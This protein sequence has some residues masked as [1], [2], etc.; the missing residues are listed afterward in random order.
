MSAAKR[1]LLW[2]VLWACATLGGLGLGLQPQIGTAGPAKARGGLRPTAVGRGPVF[3]QGKPPR[4]RAEIPATI[5]VANGPTMLGSAVYPAQDIPLRFTHD[6]H[7]ALGLSCDRCHGGAAT[8]KRS[9]DLLIPTGEA[10]DECH[11][12]QH[13]R[14]DDEPMRCTLCHTQVEDGDRLTASVRM[15]RPLLHFNHEL[16]TRRGSDCKDCHDMS[17]VRLGS[18]LQLPSEASCLSCH[19]G[20]QATARCGACHPAGSDGRLLMRA[21]DDRTLPALIP[22]GAS[23]WGAAHDLNF[24]ED[25]AAIS[26]SNGKL[27]NSCHDDAFCID[28]HD[29]PIRPMR[30]HAGDYL[31]IHAQDARAAISDCQSCHRTQSFCQ[32]CHDRVGFGDRQDGE[33]GVGGALQFHPPDW[34]GPPGMPQGHAHA[35]QRNIGTCVSC[36]SEDSCLSCHATTGAARPGLDVSPHGPGFARSARCDALAGHNRRM[37]LRCHA[38]GDPQL[39]CL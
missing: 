31:T 3:R 33:F 25:H 11:G 35:A 8:S 10:C 12:Q 39:E 30:I 9:A 37:C 38:P 21:Q 17:H 18:V 13:P 23:A 20:F 2:L 4:E 26:K 1:R 34:A 24:V 29:G 14:P 5:G 16:H 19:D 6:R 28:C 7:L 32:A 36:H 27:C 15:P 22:R